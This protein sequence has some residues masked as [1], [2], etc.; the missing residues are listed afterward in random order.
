M[1]LASDQIHL[2]EWYLFT[3]NEKKKW[4]KEEKNLLVFSIWHIMK[5]KWKEREREREKKTSNNDIY[6]EFHN[7]LL[8]SCQSMTNGYIYLFNE[9]QIL[10]RRFLRCDRI[11]IPDFTSSSSLLQMMYPTVL[12]FFICIYAC[13]CAL[14]LNFRS[15]IHWYLEAKSQCIISSFFF[16]FFPLYISLFFCLSIDR[17]FDGHCPMYMRNDKVALFLKMLN[18][19]LMPF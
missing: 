18:S 19:L 11:E 5:M 7:N 9:I 1:I 8:S 2:W 10:L 16:S 6:F 17:V 4:K 13:A 3:K 14:M 15:S 12:S